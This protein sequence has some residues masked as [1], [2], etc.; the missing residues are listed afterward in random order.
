MEID[1]FEDIET[2][3]LRRQDCSKQSW[4]ENTGLLNLSP[5]LINIIQTVIPLLNGIQKN[6][7]KQKNNENQ[8]IETQNYSEIKKE[9]AM[10]YPSINPQF[11]KNNFFNGEKMNKC[12]KCGNFS[13]QLQ[14]FN[15][16]YSKRAI[17]NSM[18]QHRRMVDYIK[19][20]KIKH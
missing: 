13:A 16:K 8:V 2:N 9:T 7:V 5:Q 1:T 19:N 14:D 4:G 12:T 10:E 18:E 20:Q 11:D 3:T 15:R 6:E 17:E